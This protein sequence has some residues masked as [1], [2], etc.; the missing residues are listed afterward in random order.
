MI[1]QDSPISLQATKGARKPN[2]QVTVTHARHV[3]SRVDLTLRMNG[4]HGTL[5]DNASFD[6]LSRGT[7]WSKSV[8]TFDVARTLKPFDYYWFIF[9][10]WDELCRLV[11]VL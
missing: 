7:D 8:L 10:L 1:V 3:C 4:M 2:L 5:S 6:L 11:R 9:M